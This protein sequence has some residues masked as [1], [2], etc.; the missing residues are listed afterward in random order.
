VARTRGEIK[1]LVEA[2]TGRTKDTL[3]NSLCNTALKVALLRHPFKDAQSVPSDFTITEA[4]TS[5]DISSIS[6]LR[7]IISARIVEASGS[8]NKR[9]VC[10]TRTYWDEY[11][12]NSEDNQKGWPQ[13]GMRV[14][15]T[16]ELD[17]PSDSGLELRLRVTTEQTFTN[18]NT[19]CP[20]DVL[21][22][23]V[24]HYVTAHIFKSLENEEM[25]KQWIL[26]ALGMR[27]L[28]DGTVGGTLA[29]AIAS[30]SIGDMA[31]DLKAEPHDAPS[32][33]S[34]G[35]SVR[36]LVTG[37]D[38]YGNTSTR[39]GARDSCRWRCHR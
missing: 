23:F 25:Y 30:D 21:D 4:A 13:F 8:R 16:I 29:D 37:H 9:L 15:T 31:L 12:I 6:G 2:H 35:V 10:K 33:H 24:E 26:T 22:I 17:R 11:V 36:N 39:H 28:I 3:E 38:D 20:I 34:A 19:D 5:V 27:Y 7:S 14:G 32:A 18:D 1:T